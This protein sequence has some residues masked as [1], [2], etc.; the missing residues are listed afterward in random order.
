MRY[1]PFLDEHGITMSA[2]VPDTIVNI[3]DNCLAIISAYT[4]NWGTYNGRE[5]KPC[6]EQPVLLTGQPIGQ[7]HCPICGMMQVAGMPHSN[8][9][10]YEQE[11]G[12]PWPPGYRDEQ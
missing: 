8:P 7:Y 9:L 1:T 11:Y 3:V 4:V 12:R 2:D 6:S 5:R 10:N